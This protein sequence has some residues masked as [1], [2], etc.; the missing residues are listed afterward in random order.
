MRR[1][2]SAVFAFLTL[3]AA[4]WSGQESSLTPAETRGKEIFLRGESR[5]G[6]PVTAFF[7][8]DRLELP[9]SAAACGSCHGSDGTGRAE[10]GLVPTNVTWKYLTKSY[11]HLHED[12]MQHPPFDSESV[13]S[14]LLTGMY[15]GGGRGDPSMPTYKMAG[16][17]LED[18][19][20]Y[21]KRLD[22]DLDPGLTAET[23]RVGTLLSSE[24][25][26]SGISRTIRRVLEAYFDQLNREGGLYGR[27]FVFVS[28]EL[29]SQKETVLGEV[30]AWLAE[31]A[32]FAL[33]SSFT[34]GLEVEVQKALAEKS[35][36]LIGTF[37]LYPVTSFA[38]NRNVFYL[39]PGLVEQAQA[40]VE[41]AK[42][43]GENAEFRV[44]LLYPESAPLDDV[45]T[46]VERSCRMSGWPAPLLKSF[47]PSSFDA[48]G[49]ARS[50]RREGVEIVIHFGIEMEIRTFMKA[51][52]NEGWAPRVLASGVLAG[53]L[54]REAPSS[55][56]K[57]LYL[58]YPTLPQDRKDWALRELFQ[59]MK[60][61]E[62]PID[63][64]QA[65]VSAYAAA[66]VA[67]EGMRRSGRRLSR[68]KLAES[69]E[70]FYQFDTGLTPPLTYTRNRR[71]GAKGAYVLVVEPESRPSDV[72]PVQWVDLESRLEL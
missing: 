64:I 40:L 14:Y 70:D 66:K 36:P 9:G 16:S 34:P 8:A 19:V 58:A 29:S 18:L 52:A 51:A 39:F 5:S 20:A 6:S 46:A 55:F 28:R 3:S 72:A 67:V 41:F 68:V 56:R 45:V 62:I 48:A 54:L 26:L 38:L 10:S 69:L 24:E 32:P 37:T 61:H 50:L 21:L 59:L 47:S 11:G 2:W 17:D 60:T 7:G 35:V 33:V 15:P 1:R 13:A 63:H 43:S 65:V 27:E 71:M 22:D 49:A 23:I 53:S 12:G 42:Q 25:R 44:A 57:R 30:Q 31:A 4:A